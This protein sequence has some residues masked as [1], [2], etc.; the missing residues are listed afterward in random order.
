[1][2]LDAHF[3]R[4]SIYARLAVAM[5]ELGGLTLFGDR[6]DTHPLVIEH[7]FSEYRVKTKGRGRVV[8]EWKP[9]P[10]WSDH[11]WGTRLRAAPWRRSGMGGM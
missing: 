9:R 2:L 3:W 10:E 8:N 4:S 6:A 1:V 5:G 7:L 11:P